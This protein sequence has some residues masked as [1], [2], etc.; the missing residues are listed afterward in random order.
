MHRHA[1]AYRPGLGPRF[2]IEGA[3]GIDAGGDGRH[4]IQE[5][6]LEGVA[7][8]FVVVPPVSP[9]RFAEDGVVS[10]QGWTHG[11]SVTLPE[12]S[13]ALDVGEEKGDDSRGESIR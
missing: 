2:G 6:G 7:D 10:L 11:G 9:N 5:G 13:G 12:P 4:G 3:L 8:R 1:H